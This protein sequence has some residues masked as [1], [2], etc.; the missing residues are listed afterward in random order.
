MKSRTKMGDPTHNV[1]ISSNNLGNIYPFELFINRTDV[2]NVVTTL[3]DSG[4]K[5]Y[6]YKD[7]AN[8][9]FDN[10]QIKN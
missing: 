7:K 6:I 3:V 9:V 5:L 4:Y 8:N 1:I 10:S 2:N